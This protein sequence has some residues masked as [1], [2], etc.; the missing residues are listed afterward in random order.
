MI[1]SYS[2]R[3]CFSSVEPWATCCCAC[4][5]VVEDILRTCKVAERTP[6][7][8]TTP[9]K[10]KQMIISDNSS[11]V[12]NRPAAKLYAKSGSSKG[13]SIRERFHVGWL[14]LGNNLSVPSSIVRGEMGLFVKWHSNLCSWWT[15]ACHVGLRD[16][17]VHVIC[18]MAMLYNAF[19]RIVSLW[20]KWMFLTVPVKAISSCYQVPP[21]P[22]HFHGSIREN[23]L[24]VPEHIQ[25]Y[26]MRWDF[27]SE[28]DLSIIGCSLS[29]WWKTFMYPFNIPGFRK[30]RQGTK[31]YCLLV[32]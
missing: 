15:K 21:P 2:G 10:N 26:L 12:R 9:V 1:Y 7:G 29:I 27:I 20:V 22:T 14:Q 28:L 18:Y 13:T 24:F 5:Y 30:I 3:F 6:S 8:R 4:P 31:V 23:S 17:A 19:L 32:I 11:T 25:I 16:H